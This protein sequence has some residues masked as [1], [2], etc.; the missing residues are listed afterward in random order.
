MAFDHSFQLGASSMELAGSEDWIYVGMRRGKHLWRA[1]LSLCSKAEL[2]AENRQS[3]SNHC[4][5]WNHET[6]TVL[7]QEV[8]AA[9][10]GHEWQA[11]RQSRAAQV[12]M[13]VT[14][15]AHCDLSVHSF[16][17][18]LSVSAKVYLSWHPLAPCSGQCFDKKGEWKGIV[19][20]GGQKLL[21]RHEKGM[22]FHA[23]GN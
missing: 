20:A 2:V 23:E 5:L 8:F 13:S 17:Q 22:G 7:G 18:A 6:Q 14:H 9:H 16:T 11:W 3:V 21:E 10:C 19:L 15:K 12:L 4:C 1:R